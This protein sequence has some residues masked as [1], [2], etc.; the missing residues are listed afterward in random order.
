MGDLANMT[1]VYGEVDGFRLLR[2]L[3]SREQMEREMAERYAGRS[4]RLTSICH[5]TKADLLKGMADDLEA[6]LTPPDYPDDDGESVDLDD[7]ALKDVFTVQGTAREVR[8]NRRG[9]WEAQRWNDNC[10]LEFDSME[11]A[12]KAATPPVQ[13]ERRT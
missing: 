3:R 8:R 5:G 6:E 7:P 4:Y 13:E 12:T 2:W 9:K 1:S 10:W 11:A